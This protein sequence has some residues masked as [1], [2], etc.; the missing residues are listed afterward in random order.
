MG[1]I[2]LLSLINISPF[3]DFTMDY[4]YVCRHIL[5]IDVLSE[6]GHAITYRAQKYFVFKDNHFVAK[7]IRAGFFLRIDAVEFLVTIVSR[8]LARNLC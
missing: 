2:L 5:R 1:S 6:L 4:I 7:D 3:R 8:L